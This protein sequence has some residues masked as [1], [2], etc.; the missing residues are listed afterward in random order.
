MFFKFSG[1]FPML[2]TKTS[3]DYHFRIQGNIS[4][5]FWNSREILPF[6]LSEW[7]FI[8]IKD[9]PKVPIVYTH[10]EQHVKTILWNYNANPNN[11]KYSDEISQLLIIF[12]TSTYTSNIS[13]FTFEG[14]N[15]SIFYFKQS[16]SSCYRYNVRS[17]S[18]QTTNPGTQGSSFKS[19]SL[20]L[21]NQ[22]LL[23]PT[24]SGFNVQLPLS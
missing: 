16:S 8:F 3:I 9:K 2:P 22:Y 23:R 13:L 24:F 21:F 18:L 4:K 11:N 17:Q 7:Y 20:P 1:V 5:M 15:E 14:T 12:L 10:T 6:I 19:V